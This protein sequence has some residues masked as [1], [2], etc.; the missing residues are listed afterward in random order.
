MGNAHDPEETMKQPPWSRRQFLRRVG[1]VGAGLAALPILAACGGTATATTAPAS[2]ASAKPSTAASAAASSAPASSAPASA[3]AS[4]AGS[5]KPSAAA[6]AAG[7]AA[8]A[9]TATP[10]PT[11]T[12]IAS[13]PRAKSTAKVTGK[14]TFIQN[15]D[16]HPDHNAFLRTEIQEF[17]KVQGWNLDIS[18]A[19]GFQGTGD[20]LSALAAAVQAGNSPDAFFQD[21]STRQYE[22]QGVL[23]DADAVTKEAIQKYGDTYPGYIETT[24]IKDK[25]YGLPFYGRAGGAYIREDWFQ[26]AGLDPVKDIETYDKMRDAALKI[27]DPSKQRWGWGM[28]PNRSGDGTTNV[29]QPIMRF[30]G[31][32]QDKDGQKITFNSPETIAGFNW[33]KETYSDKKWEKMWPAGLLSWTDTSNNEA[34]LAGTIGITDNAGT[35]YAKAQY[36]KVPHA[37][38]ILF[39]KRPKRNSDGLYLDSLSGARL[40]Y[41]KGTKNRDA[42][43]DLFRHLISEPIQKQLFSISLAYVMPPYKNLWNDPVIQGDRNAKAAFDLAYPANYFA[44]YRLPGPPS[45]ALDTITGGTY[46]TDA[47]ADILQGKKVEDVV[48]DYHKRFV[49][50]FKDQGL[51]GE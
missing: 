12:V 26:E 27:S 35:M 8:P 10:A 40:H 47:C 28:T 33:L 2:A 29:Q 34:F 51:K 24:V 1:L 5:A 18:Y 9:A 30:G 13:I 25:W 14:Y 22:F 3:A 11:P 15:Q 46:F 17:C 43:T 6:S 37:S 36:D 38:K 32:I 20:L 7:S 23:D 19:A 31:T 41:V 50:I 48:L 45:A 49:Q 44:G 16:F 4:A 42:S 21:I 39:V